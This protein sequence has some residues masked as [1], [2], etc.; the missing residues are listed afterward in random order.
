[1]TEIVVNQFLWVLCLAN[2]LLICLLLQ[3][4]NEDDTKP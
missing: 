1:M 3:I 4:A 2:Y